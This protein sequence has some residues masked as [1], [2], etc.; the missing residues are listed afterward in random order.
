VL[1]DHR[2]GSVSAPAYAVIF[3]L[4]VAA[5]ALEETTNGRSWGVLA[6]AGLVVMIDC[7]IDLR[8]PSVSTPIRTSQVTRTLN[9]VAGIII[10]A[11][12]IVLGVL[13]AAGTITFN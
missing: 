2:Y 1:S 4:G 6:L 9:A 11:V 8:R 3:I 7:A 12:F 10:G 13:A 5:L